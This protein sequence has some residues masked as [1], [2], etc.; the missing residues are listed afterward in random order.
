MVNTE[1]GN[2]YFTA[3]GNFSARK[4]QPTIYIHC[5]LYSVQYIVGDLY[6]SIILIFSSF[7]MF[8]LKQY[9]IHITYYMIYRVSLSKIDRMADQI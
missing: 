3:Q 9:M 8:S 1:V 7:N 6:L 4:A 2:L 5:T